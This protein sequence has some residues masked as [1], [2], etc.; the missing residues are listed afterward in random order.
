M[1]STSA[2][3]NTAAYGR[4][5]SAA[6]TLYSDNQTLI[7]EIRKAVIM[8]KEIA[9]DL[10]RDSKSEMLKE[11]EDGV[12]QLVKASD[13]CTHLSNAIQ[14]IGN[15][16]QPG[17]ELTNFSKLFDDKIGRSKAESSSVS[18]NHLWLRQF[19]EA[20]WN[21]HHE[22]QPM[23]GEEQEDIIMTST[24][25]NLLNITCPLTGKPVTELAEPVRSMDCK[26]IYEKKPIIQHIRSKVSQGRCPVTGC[27]KTLRADRVVCDP[28][29]LVEIDEMRSMSKQRAAEVIEDFTQLDEED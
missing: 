15:E 5:A 3:R 7:A 2:P 23:P 9:V 14:S 25:S 13:D 16:Y 22:G 6:S 28:L 20:V 17:A 24:E 29:L 4:I 26:H 19:R 10:E 27:P 8:M 1:A 18:Q 11:L 12:L 21:V